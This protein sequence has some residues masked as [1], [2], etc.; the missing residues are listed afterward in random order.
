MM[1]VYTTIMLAVTIVQAAYNILK[2]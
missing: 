1:Y 2:G